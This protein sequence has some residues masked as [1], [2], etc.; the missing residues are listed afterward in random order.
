MNHSKRGPDEIVEADTW[1]LY[2]WR[3]PQMALYLLTLTDATTADDLDTIGSL[4]PTKQCEVIH[5]Y[6]SEYIRNAEFELT[7]LYRLKRAATAA[8]SAQTVSF[9]A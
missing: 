9:A 8:T 6:E 5:E 7:T 4:V 2:T 3:E 1:R